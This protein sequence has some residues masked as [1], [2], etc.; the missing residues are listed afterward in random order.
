MTVDV[1]AMAPQWFRTALEQMPERREVEVN[2]A[3]ISL[4][5]WGRAEDPGLVLVHGGSAHSGWWDHIAPLLASSHRIVA[6]DLSGHGDSEARS[7]YPMSGWADEVIAAASAGGIAGPPMVIG[8]SMGGWVATTVGALHGDDVAGLV[9]I[10]SPLFDEP[11]EEDINWQLNR[12]PRAYPSKE[13]ICRRFR[14]EPEQE[15]TLPWVLRHVASESVRQTTD[16]WVWKFD[17]EMFRKRRDGGEHGSM[18]GLLKRVWTP[19]FFVRC[20]RGLVNTDMARE[21]CTLFGAEPTMVELAV[22][23][24]HPMLDQPLSL[25][26]TLRTVLAVHTRMVK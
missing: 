10:D 21:M 26:A 15:N 18:R 7:R 22:A 12:K 3:L 20:E 23:G 14:T 4:R 19:I 2:G 9:M 17:P 8:H 6:L 16:G 24:H 11:P 1:P 5:C 13:E 25:V